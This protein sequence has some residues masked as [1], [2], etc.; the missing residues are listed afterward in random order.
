[1]PS[2]V[3]KLRIA[4]LSA[5]S[6]PVPGKISSQIASSFNRFS[7]SSHCNGTENTPPPSRYFA[8]NPH[9]RKIVTRA[10]S[11][12]CSRAQARSIVIL[13]DS[14][15]RQMRLAAEDVWLLR[16]A[17]A[18]SGIRQRNDR[19]QELRLPPNIKFLLKVIPKPDQLRLAQGRAIHQH[20]RRPAVIANTYGKRQARITSLRWTG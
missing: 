16:Q 18:N 11:L 19:I 13:E 6:F 12:L 3:L 17:G 4:R 9:P 14:S 2:C 8:A 20:S 10:E 15:V 5:I 1:M 7:P